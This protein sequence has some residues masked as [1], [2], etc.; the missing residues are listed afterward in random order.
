MFPAHDYPEL[1]KFEHLKGNVG[2]AWFDQQELFAE[3]R[4]PHRRDIELRDAPIKY[5]RR[6]VLYDLGRRARGSYP[7]RGPLCSA[8]IDHATELQAAEGW[9]SDESFPTG[10]YHETVLDLAPEIVAAVED[11]DIRHF[12]VIAGCDAPTD[13]REYY[14]KLAKAVPEDYLILT[15]GCGKVRF[16]DLE[17]G[18][19]PGTNNP[20]FLDVG[21]CNNSISMVKI[22]QGLAEAFACGIKDF[23]ASSCFRGSSG[24]PSRSS[25]G[26]S[27]SGPWTA[28]SGRHSR[29]GSPTRSSRSCRQSS[30]CS[31]P[32]TPALT[33]MRCSGEQSHREYP[34]RRGSPAR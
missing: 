23:P 2:R 10:F 3:F 22:A 4:G 32:E 34:A 19:V 8:A 13:G 28:G 24:R 7:Y 29:N 1:A 20:R 12:F 27:I 6:P 26:C 15:T 18:T 33:P 21:Q 11:G 30:I 17:Y 14:R 31:R 16:N 25:S 9:D 5:L